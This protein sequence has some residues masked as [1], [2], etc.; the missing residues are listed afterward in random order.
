MSQY[1]CKYVYQILPDNTQFFYNLLFNIFCSFYRPATKR[2]RLTIITS[3]KLQ[4]QPQFDGRRL[5][6]FFLSFITSTKIWRACRNPYTTIIKSSYDRRPKGET[7]RLFQQHTKKTKH[8]DLRVYVRHK[9]L[10]KKK[11]PTDL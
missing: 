6:Y 4:E 1:I 8:T 3:L 2:G 9:N 7:H 10:K 11:E 5:F